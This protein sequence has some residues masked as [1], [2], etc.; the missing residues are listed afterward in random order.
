MEDAWL[1]LLLVVEEN[2]PVEGPEVPVLVPVLVLVFV[3]PTVTV[4]LEWESWWARLVFCGVDGK[5]K[6]SGVFTLFPQVAKGL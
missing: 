1:L 3:P 4:P 2:I 5:C 6:C